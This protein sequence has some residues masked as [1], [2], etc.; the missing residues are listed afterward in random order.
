MT[1]NISEHGPENR[2]QEASEPQKKVEPEVEPD[3]K[4]TAEEPDYSAP[5]YWDE[6]TTP[7]G[8]TYYWN[9]VTRGT[10][11]GRV[12]FNLLQPTRKTLYFETKQDMCS[13][14]PPPCA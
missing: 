12:V 4:P 9:T 10:N 13:H 7:E 2:P 3:N 5:E 6:D 11:A 1:T 8:Y 14:F